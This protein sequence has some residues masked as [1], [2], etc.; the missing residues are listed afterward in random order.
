MD[1]LKFTLHFEFS[2]S[3]VITK[4]F[5]TGLFCFLFF[6]PFLY[7]QQN[8]EPKKLPAADSLSLISTPNQF[9]NY[10]AIHNEFELYHFFNNPNIDTSFNNDMQTLWLRTSISL[11]NSAFSKSEN[12]PHYLLPLYNSYLENSKFDPMRTVLGLAQAGAVGYLAYLHT[13]KYGF[14][15]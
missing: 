15:K 1:K 9:Y 7:A 4:M 10:D 2:F 11:S 6:F 12:T 14:W 5:F 8:D 13:K 3:D